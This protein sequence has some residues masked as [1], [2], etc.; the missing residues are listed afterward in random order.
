MGWFL[1]V[2]MV[3]AFPYLSFGAEK[4]LNSFSE[5]VDRFEKNSA[6]LREGPVPDVYLPI[7]DFFNFASP[8]ASPRNKILY[9]LSSKIEILD[10]NEPLLE[11]LKKHNMVFIADLVSLS[12]EDLLSEIHLSFEDVKTIKLRL[13]KSD[14]R[15]D[16]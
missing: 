6:S 3:V 8:T 2:L 9:L 16:M 12:E 5:D 7:A 1:M 13:A 15:L 4:C 14:L 10:F 11:S